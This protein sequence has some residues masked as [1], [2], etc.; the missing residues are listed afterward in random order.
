MKSKII[1]QGKFYPKD[2][3]V[4]FADFSNRKIDFEIENEIDKNWRKYEKIR[5]KEGG[6]I[7]DSITYRLENLKEEGCKVNVL[8]GE[9]NFFKRIGARFSLD[10]IEK[11]GEDYYP[12]GIYLAA[13]IETKDNYFLLGNLTKNTTAVNKNN[14]IGGILSKDEMPVKDSNDIFESLC[15]EIFEELNIKKEKIQDMFLKSIIL[16]ERL[17]AG[18]I[19]YVKLNVNREDVENTFISNNEVSGLD[20]YIEDEFKKAL[21]SI[22][23]T[24]KLISELV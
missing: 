21:K 9:I 22:D 3:E 23:D 17:A 13:I 14:L 4:E 16:S 24:R 19:F 1:V 7:W 8:L 15:N 5:K 11:L 20:F 12:M 18:F 6:M 2:I 10:K